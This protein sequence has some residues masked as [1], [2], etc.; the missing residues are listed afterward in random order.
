MGED[1]PDNI[2]LLL[3]PR[4]GEH[5]DNVVSIYHSMRISVLMGGFDL[6]TARNNFHKWDDQKWA[7]L[8]AGMPR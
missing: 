6:R 3:G 4:W 1:T 5:K 2:S 7:E 8:T